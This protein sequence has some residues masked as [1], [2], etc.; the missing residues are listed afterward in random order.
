MI[1]PFLHNKSVMRP[2]G[3]GLIIYPFS[4]KTQLHAHL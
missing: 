4:T 3:A 1:D 2:A